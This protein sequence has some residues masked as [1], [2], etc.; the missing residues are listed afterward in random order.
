M[1]NDKSILKEILGDLKRKKKDRFYLRNF[2][3]FILILF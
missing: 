2:Q 1:K 3:I